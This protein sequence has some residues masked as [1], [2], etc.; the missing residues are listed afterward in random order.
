MARTKKYTPEETLR[1]LFNLQFIDS[2]IDNMREVRGELPME[3]KDLEDEMVGLNK[4]LEKV[5]E[6]TEGLNQLILEKKNII[7]ESKSSI[8][9]YLEKQKN[10]R[11]NREFDSLSK[12]IEYQELEAQLAEK[13]IKENSARIDGK[14]E[15]LEEIQN[16]HKSKEEA[17]E[18][19]K[20]ELE[21][22]ISETEREEKIL[23]EES[24]KASKSIDERFLKAYNRIRGASKNG[25]AVVP[26]E[27]GASGG[28]FIKIPPQVQ[29]DIAARKK[30]IVD[31]HSGRIL[32]DALLADEQSTKMNRKI[33]KVL[34][35]K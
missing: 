24:L 3:V 27:R 32:V 33:N 15:I 34:S 14:K 35:A 5:E 11:N 18:A 16:L 10:V 7:E 26:V 20:K 25:L 30:I 12:E 8:K 1:S 2:R 21:E 29:L 4:R 28:S 23:M 17:L 6:E 9:K 19:K 31:E 13:R 22:I